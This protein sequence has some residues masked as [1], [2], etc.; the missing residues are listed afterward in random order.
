MKLSEAI[1]TQEYRNYRIIKFRY[2]VDLDEPLVHDY[3]TRP[4]R[5][6]E[7]RFWWAIESLDEKPMRIPNRSHRFQTRLEAENF[8][9][10]L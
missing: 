2:F 6:E 7:A 4:S 1:A 3:K 8:I 5:L 10:R 9:D